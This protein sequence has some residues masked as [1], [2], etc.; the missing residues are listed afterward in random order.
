MIEQVHENEAPAPSNGS[1]CA[2]PLAVSTE[3]LEQRVSRLECAVA[4]MQ[5]SPL[6]EQRIVERVVERLKDGTPAPARESANLVVETGRRLLPMAVGI[7]APTAPATAAVEPDASPA[8]PWL[9]YEAYCEA[10]TMLHMYLDPRYRHQMTWSG[11]VVPLV[12]LAAI[13]TTYIWL[14]GS[15]VLPDIVSGPIIKLVDLVLAF[16][17]FKVLHREAQRYKKAV[18]TP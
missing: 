13:F 1:T 6:A 8:R 15:A 18:R 16:I 10:R 9:L 14:P 4:A 17:L 11:R 12:L 2:V 7:V 5:D 3:S